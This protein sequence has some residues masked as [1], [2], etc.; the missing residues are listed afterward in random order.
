[1]RGPLDCT[2]IRINCVQRAPRRRRTGPTPRRSQQPPGHSVRRSGLPPEFPAAAQVAAGGLPL[3]VKIRASNQANFG[4]KIVYRNYEQPIPRIISGASPS[5]SADVAW[6]DQRATKTGRR[7]D[8]FGTEPGN[9]LAAPPAVRLRTL[10]LL[11]VYLLQSERRRQYRERLRRR[12]DFAFDVASR[13][14]TFLHTEDRLAGLAV[15]DKKVARL[16][17][18]ADRGNPAV[19]SAHVEQHRRRRYIIVPEIVVHGLKGPDAPAG[20]SVQSHDGIRKQVVA[21]PFASI[22]IGARA[23]R[24][25][26]QQIAAGI[27]GNNRPGI[28]PPSTAGALLLPGIGAGF[29]WAL[30]NRIPRPLQLASDHIEA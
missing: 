5:H 19:I 22:V 8:P 1:W 10:D 7:E 24:W 23:A 21:D 11:R 16:R 13:N 28:R 14:R 26:E 9:F 3:A 17:S 15:Q 4:S 12:C 18:N 27:N 25:H 30:R 2:G 20:F 29:L 6:N